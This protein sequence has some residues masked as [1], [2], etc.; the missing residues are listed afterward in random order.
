MPTLKN[1]RH[2]RFAQLIAVAGLSACEAYTQAGYKSK[3]AESNGPRLARNEQIASRIEQLRAKQQAKTEA[4]LEISRDRIVKELADMAL[5]KGSSMI[6]LKAIE[7]LNKMQGYNEPESVQHNHLH[8]T[9]NSEL[10]NEL[11]AGYAA[12]A[13]R[14]AKVCLPLPGENGGAG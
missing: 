1:P 12:L 8:L 6:K 7:L 4:K 10:I 5:A 3:S 13:E 2:E 11:R 9:V 14:N